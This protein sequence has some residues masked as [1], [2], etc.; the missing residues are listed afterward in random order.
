MS[1][2][3][4]VSIHSIT[5]PS[6]Q[7]KNPNAV[8]DVAVCLHTEYGDLIVKDC[9]L[10]RSKQ[11]GSLYFCWPNFPDDSGKFIPTI[12]ATGNLRDGIPILAVRTFEEQHSI[13]SG[14]SPVEGGEV[15]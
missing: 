13:L 8:A 15:R 10:I 5:F 14:T 11:N 4:D 6:R 3:C 2:S 1:N 12:E 9:R 7:K